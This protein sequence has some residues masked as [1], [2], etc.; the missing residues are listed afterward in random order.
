MLANSK[1]EGGP[2]NQREGQIITECLA[3]LVES[4]IECETTQTSTD[5]LTEKGLTPWTKAIGIV[6]YLHIEGALYA[7]KSVLSWF[8]AGFDSKIDVCWNLKKVVNSLIH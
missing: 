6:I 4:R 5:I 2:A 8:L 7:Q 1:S 3:V